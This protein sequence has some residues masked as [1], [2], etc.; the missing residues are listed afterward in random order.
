MVRRLIQLAEEERKRQFSVAEL[1]VDFPDDTLVPLL[2]GQLKAAT[3]EGGATRCADLAYTIQNRGI[4]YRAFAFAPRFIAG[5]KGLSDSDQRDARA[6]R[7]TEVLK[8]L[9]TIQGC[10]ELALAIFEKALKIQ[11]AMGAEIKSEKELRPEHVIADLPLN[12]SV[13]RGGDILTR[14]EDGHVAPPNLFFDPERWSQ[15][16]EHQKQCGFIY[17]PRT[18]ERL[19]GLAARIVFFE[20]FDL[21]MDSGADRASKTA[22]KIKPEWFRIACSHGLCSGDLVEIF[23]DEKPRLVPIMGIDLE[24]VIPEAIKQDD[25]GIIDR[26]KDEFRTAIPIGLPPKV[27]AAVLKIVG[28]GLAFVQSMMRSG[29][30]QKNSNL[31]EKK[32][33]QLRLR[34]FL[35]AQEV[36]TIEGTK[37][38]GG[39]TDLVVD[40]L[41]VIEN[42]VIRDPTTTPLQDGPQFSWQARRYAIAIAQRVAVEMVA[43][44]PKDET[45][46]LPLS[47]SITVSQVPGANGFARIRIVV[48]WGHDVPSKAKPP[49][50]T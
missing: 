34:Q 19:V 26:L 28:R 6:I 1:F 12:K 24:S 25:P 47:K 3:F 29:E 11:K 15:A 10:D 46:V 20:K 21:V 48:P 23:C 36:K 27:Y 5:L 30:W 16:Y 44:K 17:T 39:E 45:A 13:V 9:S 22:S 50:T 42:K 49:T 2:G 40:S 18:H 38:A 8:A 32:D 35:D 43:Y 41:L 7:W 4:Y 37:E 14:T 31:D 33:L